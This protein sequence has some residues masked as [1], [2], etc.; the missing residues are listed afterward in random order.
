MTPDGVI[1]PVDVSGDGVVGLLA[2]L[3]G[4]KAALADAQST[5]HPADREAGLLRL[6][7]AEGHRL[8]SFAKKAAAFLRCRAPA[9]GQH[10]RVAAVSAQHAH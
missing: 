9:S 8:V 1:E 10:S 6:D 3:P 4:E 5:T 2:G 7:E